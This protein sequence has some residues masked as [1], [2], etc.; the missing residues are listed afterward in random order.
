[1]DQHPYSPH[2]AGHP[3]WHALVGAVARLSWEEASIEAPLAARPV[4]APAAARQIHHPLGARDVL[5][6]VATATKP[7]KDGDKTPAKMARTSGKVERTGHIS[8]MI[9]C[10]S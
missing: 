10:G 9:G 2:L 4:V 7:L 1:M 5:L 3:A 6:A 8:N